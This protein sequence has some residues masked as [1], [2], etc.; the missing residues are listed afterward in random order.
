MRFWGRRKPLR[1]SKIDI[2]PP[3]AAQARDGIALVAIVKNEAGYIGDWLRFHA[4]AGIN[5]FIIYDNQSTDQTV[6][7]AKSFPTLNVT[8]IPWALDTSSHSPKMI[9]PCQILAYCHAISNF[10]AT[11][12]WMGFIDIDEFLVPNNSPTISDALAALTDVSNISL[13]WMMFGH[14]GHETKPHDPVP[15]AYTHRARDQ[16]GKLLNFKCIVDPCDVSQ[17][18]THKFETKSMGAKTA[19][20]LGKIAW[21]KSR[22]RQGFV[23]NAG[24]QLNHYYLRSRAE[25]A[26]KI[27]GPAV[28]GTQ[29]DQRK[30]A[31]LEKAA[32]IEDALLPDT[33]AKLFLQLHEIQTSDDFRKAVL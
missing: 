15:L 3:V 18:S 33:A 19:N 30:N 29:K 17:V 6:E 11:F 4:M 7:I 23:T 25:M 32:L 13:P 14:G 26:Q 16:S 12:R 8:V 20:M 31:I 28:S 22:D 1:A 5:D 9:L 21:N 27:A 2:T 24:L 10:G